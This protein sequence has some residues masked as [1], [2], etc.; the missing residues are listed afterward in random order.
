LTDEEGFM[1]KRVHI[2]RFFLILFIASSAFSLFI[3]TEEIK[4][5]IING[6]PV[7]YNPRVPASLQ[8][9]IL[10]EDLMISG[11]KEGPEYTLSDIR[12][13][14]VDEEENIYILDLKDVRV[15][16][17]DKNGKG[18]RIFGKKGSG[19]CE[20]QLPYRMYLISGK[21][22]MF[23]DISN[24]RI[25]YY[26][27]AGQC[28]REM[29]TA[30]QMFERTIADSKG[31]IVGYFFI[32]GERY[33]HELKKF[34]PKLNPIMTIVTVEEQRAPYVIEIMDTSL[35]FRVLENDNIVWSHPS[36]YEISIISPEGKTLR[37]IMKAYYPVKI[38]EAEKKEMVE[39]STTPPGYKVK[40]PEY[41]NP[42]YYFICDEEGRIY[43]RTYERDGQVGFWHD[44]F[45]AEGRNIG[46]FSLPADEEIFIV[47]KDKMYSVLSKNGQPYSFVKRYIIEW[48]KHK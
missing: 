11:E 31:N 39:R 24:R 10:K 44:V 9:I 48:S 41:Y 15:K 36:C 21:E 47:K 35:Q 3:Q 13:V 29:S 27:L 5:K 19:S 40:I 38:S 16:V 28:L 22:L 14:Q 30:K 26:S 33:V 25:S 42:F 32:P 2:L 6:I 37:K 4:I 23:Y 20:L 17:F 12:S 7:V 45:D 46:K 34:D 18:L 43:V 1:K 8:K